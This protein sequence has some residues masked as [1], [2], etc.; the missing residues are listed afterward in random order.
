LSILLGERGI[1]R[2]K[3]RGSTRVKCIDTWRND[4]FENRFTMLRLNS[5]VD[6]I[7][8]VKRLISHKFNDPSVQQNIQQFPFKII[9]ENSKPMTEINS[10]KEQKL[11]APEEISAMILRKMR[12]TAVS[13]VFIFISL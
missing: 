12:E 3:T 7:F 4:L 9:E 10:N 8:D 2:K 13:R 5:N 6:T 1:Q 11:F